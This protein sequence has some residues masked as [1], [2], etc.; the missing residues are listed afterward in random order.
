MRDG[1]KIIADK[2]ANGPCRDP[3]KK[4]E[5]GKFAHSHETPMPTTLLIVDDDEQLRQ[6]LARRFARQGFTVVEAGR[7]EQALTEA[8]A[9]R[10]DAALLDLHLPDIDGLAL[11][12]GLKALQPDLEAIMLTAHS[13]IETAIQA[14]KRGAYDYLSKPFHLPDLDVHLEK[15]LE[16]TRLARRQRQ[17]VEQL[18]YESPRYRLVGS[19]P[20]MRKVTQL[21]EKVAGTD[22]TVLIRGPSGTGKELV[23]RPCMPTVRG[24]TTR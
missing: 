23:A 13:S 18:K 5:W 4:S 19:S 14:M 6:T 17:F 20:A 16:K 7:A 12:D 2:I 21:V 1:A 24:P 8:A 3:R 11:L 9:T 22:A 15:A 10:F